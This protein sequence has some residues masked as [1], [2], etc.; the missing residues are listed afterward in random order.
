MVRLGANSLGQPVVSH[1]DSN[2]L[3]KG[4]A[5]GGIGRASILP[6]LSAVRFVGFRALYRGSRLLPTVGSVIKRST[7]SATIEIA[8][9]RP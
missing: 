4:F 7:H 1:I 8:N 3:C 5:G 6:M 9:K 2:W